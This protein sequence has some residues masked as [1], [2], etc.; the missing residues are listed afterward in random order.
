MADYANDG[1]IGRVMRKV[2][3]YVRD[4]SVEA[5]LSDADL[6][7]LYLE[8]AWATVYDAY[9]TTGSGPLLAKVD[10]S[11]V[12]DQQ[13]YTLPPSVRRVMFVGKIGTQGYPTM[14][15]LPNS[16]LNPRGPG[17]AVNGQNLEIRPYP[18]E[19]ETYQV[20]Y[21]PDGDV[22]LHEGRGNPV[23]GESYL[24]ELAATPTFGERDRRQ[25]AYG[26]CR[27]SIF[28]ST[29]TLQYDLT[30]ASY[31]ASTRRATV[32]EALASEVTS[33]S[34]L[35]YAIVPP[36]GYSYLNTVAAKVALDIMAGRNAPIVSN[37]IE[38]EFASAIKALRSK[39]TYIQGRTPPRFKRD[40]A[41]AGDIRMPVIL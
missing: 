4:P 30:V 1:W 16:L 35:L 2:R 27:L 14:D 31:D 32:R 3:H 18:V 39:T 11:L 21:I 37:A 25:N 22:R 10:I 38:K 6:L 26:G 13:F 33:G 8:P 40:V 23:A 20:L 19:A 24:F 34:N 7:A 17:W 15:L 41:G 36:I 28:D 29:L 12:A 9:T 5:E